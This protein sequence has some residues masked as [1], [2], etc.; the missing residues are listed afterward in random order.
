M[1]PS[2][3]HLERAV[4]ILAPLMNSSTDKRARAR[5]RSRARIAD[6]DRAA[7]WFR[8]RN[9]VGVVVS[10]KTSGPDKQRGEVSLKFLVRRKIPAS[11]L[12]DSEL[13]P[14][15]L[16]LRSVAREIIT[17]VE[18][19]SF[20]PVA[21]GSVGSAG[22]VRPVAPGCSIGHPRAGGGT[23]GL[24]VRLNGE[25][26]YLSCAH[27]LAP[28]GAN[29]VQLN[30][31]IEQPA[32]LFRSVTQNVV[33][34][35]AKFTDVAADSID[36]AL[37]KANE[38]PHT[39]NVPGIGVPDQILS[40]AAA[41]FPDLNLVLVRNGVGSSQQEGSVDGFGSVN[42][43]YSD[44]GQTVT[45]NSVVTLNAQSEGGDSGAAIFVKGT[46]TV[47]GLH[48][49]AISDSQSVFFPIKAVFDALDVSL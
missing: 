7:P 47:A 23:L 4:A 30:D 14:P 45:L 21:H 38:I 35:L 19:V 12:S 36:A 31:P 26:H 24:V 39:G 44:L 34:T 5:V 6:M 16:K 33:G 29:S 9:V 37:A 11:R 1:K 15:L 17:D 46:Q 27:V 13:I 3:S 32:D 25:D 10:R 42:L 20:T 18:Q 48:V 2:N 41:D 49:G 40:Q 8:S 43:F 28:G 22:L